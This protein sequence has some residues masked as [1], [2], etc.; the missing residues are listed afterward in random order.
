MKFAKPLLCWT[1]A[2]LLTTITGS[3][4]QTQFNL[5]AIAAVG[6]PVTPGL[7]L[8]TT[9][10]DLAGFAPM[11]GLVTAAGFALAFPVA[12]YLARRWPR[13]RAH[14]YTLAGASALGAA[15]LIMNNLMNI[16]IIG[17]T[18]SVP[19]LLAIVAAGGLGGWAYAALAPGRRA[20]RVA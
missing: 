14:L 10:Q 2:A 8:Q 1:I 16:T 12:A 13:Y 9:L 20:A 7:R 6:A 19:G 15:I 11:F 3:V 18:R 17:A 5:A 4:L